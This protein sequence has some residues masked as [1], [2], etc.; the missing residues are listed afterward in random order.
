LQ[1]IW[2]SFVHTIWRILRIWTNWQGFHKTLAS[3]PLIDFVCFNHIWKM[4][5]PLKAVAAAARV[6]FRTA[7]RWVS[8]YRQF[9]L[10]GLARKKRTDNG[11]HR[12]ISVK[13]KEVIEG[14]A[15]QKPP[16]PVASIFRYRLIKR[17]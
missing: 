1:I 6:P 16:L 17:E 15:L 9:G 8:L 2:R 11:R 10:A 13:L 12:E 7:Q 3:S 5:A 4:T 14:L